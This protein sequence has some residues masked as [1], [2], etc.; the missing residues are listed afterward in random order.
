VR[1]F[2]SDT[3]VPIGRSRG[4]IDKL[5][6]DWGASAIQWSDEYDLDRVTLRFIW[7]SH[8]TRFMA[9]FTLKLRTRKELEP[10]ALDGRT[11][12]VSEGKIQRLLNDR[13]KQEHR[14]LLLWIKAALN[15]VDLGIV[16]AEELFLPFLEGADGKTVGEVAMPRLVKL[17]GG[18][19]N[20]LLG[21]GR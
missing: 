21:D 6:R 3:A 16:S 12:Q 19:A 5:L 20:L 7:T 1:R 9:R 13:G 4:E 10:A 14:V 18:G 15:A 2:A 8:G 17:V 11:G